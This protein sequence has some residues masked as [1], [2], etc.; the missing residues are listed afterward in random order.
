MGPRHRLSAMPDTHQPGSAWG[1]GLATT[2]TDG[3]VL[4]VWYPR[5]M[6]GPARD[7]DDTEL[8]ALAANDADRGVRQ[9]VVRTVSDLGAPPV[10]AA[11][12]YLRLHLLSHRLVRP[13]GVDLSGIFAAL[14]NNAWTSHGPVPVEEIENVRL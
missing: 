4:D 5:P 9:S 2:T 13:H 14:P 3:T 10:D 12:A 7:A 11:D 8:R 1:I 6:L